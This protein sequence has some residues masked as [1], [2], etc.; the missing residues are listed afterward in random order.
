MF[1]MTMKD[2]S[3]MVPEE[4]IK[5]LRDKRNPVVDGYIY[6]HLWREIRM[7]IDETKIVVDIWSVNEEAAGD[8]YWNGAVGPQTKFTLL[9]ADLN[10][11]ENINNMLQYEMVKTATKVKEMLDKLRDVVPTLP[12][13]LNTLK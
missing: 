7:D 3:C 6:D 4:R 8:G 13:A 9:W 12:T 1:R 2:W 5:Q 11:I 10:D